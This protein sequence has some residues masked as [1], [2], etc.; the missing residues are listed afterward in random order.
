MVGQDNCLIMDIPHLG[1]RDVALRNYFGAHERIILDNEANLC[2]LAERFTDDALKNTRNMVFVFLSEGIGCGLVIDGRIYRGPS[3]SAGE[4]GHMSIIENGARCYCGNT[5]CWETI[6]STEA[7]VDEYE[8]SGRVLRGEGYGNKF[9]SLV[10]MAATDVLAAGLLGA[11]ESRLA[12]GII[13]IVNICNPEVV[14]LG[15]D[16]SS[17]PDA[18]IERIN[19][20]VQSRALHPTRGKVRVQKS[21]LR[22]EGRR[23]ANSIGAA[24]L[25]IDKMLEEII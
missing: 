3:F 16:A 4:F 13:N 24:L 9:K 14:I 23:G 22:M 12:R 17:L 6:A 10:N 20:I 7:I 19:S 8:T 11:E 21:R 5:G 15:G 25:A 2:V 1:W 18:S